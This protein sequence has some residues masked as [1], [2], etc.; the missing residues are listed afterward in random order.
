MPESVSAYQQAAS[1]WERI[2][3]DNPTDSHARNELAA[4]L[5]AVA[6]GKAHLGLHDESLRAF[7]QSLAILAPFV[8]A[9][10]ADSYTRRLLGAT[11]TGYG[12]EQERVGQT[13]AALRSFQEAVPILEALV[14]SNPSDAQPH[15]K[16]TGVQPGRPVVGPW[17][18]DLANAYRGLGVAQQSAGQRD[19]GT[20]FLREGPDALEGA[21]PR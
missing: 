12:H 17:Q 21:D 14:R 13:A 3:R 11:L 5:F 1:I 16:L 4:C 7:E 8:R 18:R 9:N 20:A 19:R 6:D 15:R 2:V 10:P